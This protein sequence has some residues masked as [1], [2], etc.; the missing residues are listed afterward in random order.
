[1][2]REEGFGERGKTSFPVKR[3]FSPLSGS[4][5][6]LI[7]LLVVI[8]IIAILA[9]MLLPALRNAR[10]R[11]YGTSC[12]GNLRQIALAVQNYASAYDGWPPPTQS[13]SINIVYTNDK[14]QAVKVSMQNAGLKTMFPYVQGSSN[15]WQWYHL[16]MYAGVLPK[17][18]VDIVTSINDD[19]TPENNKESTVDVESVMVCP[20]VYSEMNQSILFSYGMN[21]AIGGVH[22][23]GGPSYRA[24]T[25]LDRVRQPGK[26]FM[27]ADRRKDKFSPD[28]SSGSEAL[29][30]RATFCGSTSGIYNDFRHNKKN[31]MAFVDGH[32][33]SLGF[34]SNNWHP[35]RIKNYIH[36]VSTKSTAVDVE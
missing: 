23:S 34:H 18:A 31:N 12:T 14:E 26:A 8:A 36:E 22:T 11:S 16:L 30:V 24:W 15:A 3:S 4:A 20:M 28:K 1:M 17:P 25:K 27:I 21:E 32:V 7:E 2:K 5:F 6:T 33:Q 10:E 35:D 9:A 13:G 29:A 19:G